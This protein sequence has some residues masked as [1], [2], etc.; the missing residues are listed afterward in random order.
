MVK[1][2]LLILAFIFLTNEFSAQEIVFRKDQPVPFQ[3]DSLIGSKSTMGPLREYYGNC[4]WTQ[5]ELEL[6]CEYAKQYL[7]INKAILK[8]NVELKQPGMVL[9]T[10]HLI[11]NDA[12]NEAQAFDSVE[13]IDDDK[14]LIAEKGV[15]NTETKISVFNNRVLAE[16]DSSIVYADKVIYNRKSKESSAFGTVSLFSKTNPVILTGDTILNNPLSNRIIAKGKPILYQ[17]DSIIRD[18]VITIDTLKISCEKIIGYTGDENKYIFQDS[19]IIE[20]DGTSATAQMGIFDKLNEQIILIGA[21]IV[22]YDSTQLSGDTIIIELSENKLKSIFSSGEAFSISSNDL[23]S[24]RKNQIEG[25]T[26]QLSFLQGKLSN[27]KSKGN[28]KSLYY[29][30]DKEKKDGADIKDSD[31]LEILFKDGKVEDIY[32]YGNVNG[33]F[34]PEKILTGKE[35]DLYLPRFQW[36]NSK[37]KIPNRSIRNSR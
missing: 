26:I 36:N 15:Y 2:I 24:L 3:A 13:I 30:L 1:N 20:K 28:S 8:I 17:L 19:L 10:P 4:K 16:D 27:I 5:N 31:E 11:F 29:F 7:K 32:W 37:K 18:N 12:S 14:Y 22:Y 25:D 35:K 9:K 23:D 33:E 21:P 6:S 34:H